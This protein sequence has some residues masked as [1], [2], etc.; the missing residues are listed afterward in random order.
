MGYGEAKK[1]LFS[2]YM[3]YFSKMRTHRAE[4]EKKPKYVNE[5]LVE[6]AKKA[7]AVAEK[8]MERV[9]KAVGLS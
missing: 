7:G 4:L 5:I 9:R 2:T 1:L 8:T 3:D 6:G